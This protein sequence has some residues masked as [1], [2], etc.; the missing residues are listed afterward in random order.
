SGTTSN[1]RSPATPPPTALHTALPTNLNRTSGI[2]MAC[3]GAG[4]EVVQLAPAHCTERDEE[5]YSLAGKNA[6]GS[7]RR[8]PLNAARAEGRTTG[9][10]PPLPLPPG[11]GHD[12]VRFA[13]EGGAVS[14]P[15]VAADAAVPAPGRAHRL[16]RGPPPPRARAAQARPRGRR[17]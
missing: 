5:R 7:R 4:P 17:R 12:E 1:I 14:A 3:L 8:R 15:E 2:F 6:A 13:V 9:I 11:A 10:T 16:A